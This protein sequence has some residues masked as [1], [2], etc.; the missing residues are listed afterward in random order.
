MVA[1]QRFIKQ[2]LDLTSDSDAKKLSQT[3]QTVFGESDAT[4]V[5]PS[6]LAPHIAKVP[7]QTVIGIFRKDNSRFDRAGSVMPVA[8]IVLFEN[9]AKTGVATFEA[10]H[11]RSYGGRIAGIYDV[12]KADKTKL[13]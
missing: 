4:T 7:G 2:I 5:T 10:L 11:S 6:K 12:N 9:I 13:P 3:K 8:V 1:T